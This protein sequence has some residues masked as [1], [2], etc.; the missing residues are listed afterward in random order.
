MCNSYSDDDLYFADGTT[1][2]QRGG[3]D[4]PMAAQS[5]SDGAK[6]QAQPAL[7]ISKLICF[8]LVLAP[9]DILFTSLHMLRI[10]SAL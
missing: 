1:E 10:F 2:A 7:S 6:I 3:P 4:F 5:G 8:A 9:T